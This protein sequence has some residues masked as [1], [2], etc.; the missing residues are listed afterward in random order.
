MASGQQLKLTVGNHDAMLESQLGE[1]N[2]V[3]TALERYSQMLDQLHDEIP[4]D[5]E[6][7][8]VDPISWE[9]NASGLACRKL[10]RVTSHW[11]ALANPKNPPH[12]LIVRIARRLPKIIAEIGEGPRKILQRIRSIE[13]IN[14]L[15]ELDSAC[16]QWLVKQPGRNLIEKTGQRRSLLTIQRFES[17]DT[18]ENRVFVDFLKRARRQAHSYLQQHGPTFPN[19]NSIQSTR[20]LLRLCENLLKQIEFQSIGNLTTVPQPNYVL[21]HEPR[22]QQI[23]WGYLQ[24][25]RQSQRRR[26]LWEYRHAAWSEMCLIALLSSFRKHAEVV[27]RKQAIR[28]DIWINDR[29]E[30]G[31]KISQTTQMPLWHVNS[32]QS[33]FA[34]RIFELGL[35]LKGDRPKEF[36]A[37]VYVQKNGK[38]TVHIFSSDFLDDGKTLITSGDHTAILTVTRYENSLNSPV[39][40]DSIQLPLILTNTPEH[41]DS[42]VFKLISQ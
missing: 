13:P 25:V 15:R 30:S 37:C 42:F 18:L 33:F 16:I 17:L 29:T 26:N 7:P 35:P 1:E 12:D 27:A 38:Q 9:G 32:H 3:L 5:T 2:L 28:S 31:I 20:R 41:F 14:R 6:A 11:R 39:A 8:S 21:L 23:W 24:L 36:E 19:H 40:V 34:G 4:G 10:G 22:Y